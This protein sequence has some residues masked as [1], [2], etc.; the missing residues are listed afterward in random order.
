MQPLGNLVVKHDNN[1]R[2]SD[3]SG[4]E[5]DDPYVVDVDHV[6]DALREKVLTHK[7]DDVFSFLAQSVNQ[8]AQDNNLEKCER[9]HWKV[10]PSLLERALTIVI[11]GASGDLAKKKTFPALFQL[12]CDGLLPPQINIVGYARSKIDN[13]ES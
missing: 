7:P 5:S 10:Q 12:Y 13:V 11:L 8:L 2:D 1:R 9:I 3:A 6:L 4:S